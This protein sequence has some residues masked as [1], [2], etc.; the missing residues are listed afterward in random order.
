MYLWWKAHFLP[1]GNFQMLTG[2]HMLVC[3]SAHSFGRGTFSCRIDQCNWIWLSSGGLEPALWCRW[4][5]H[6][7]RYKTSRRYQPTPWLWRDISILSLWFDLKQIATELVS[8]LC[9]SIRSFKPYQKSSSIYVVERFQKRIY[10]S[11]PHYWKSN[12]WPELCN[13]ASK[14]D[15]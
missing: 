10:M 5:G 11:C 3:T 4:L 2:M 9:I 14:L 7:D 1:Q 12:Y 6:C 13:G 8:L 15:K